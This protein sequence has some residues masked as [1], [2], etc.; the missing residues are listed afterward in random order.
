MQSEKLTDKSKRRCGER[1]GKGV[2]GE[3]K[4][5]MVSNGKAGDGKAIDKGN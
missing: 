5:S 3:T 2:Q 1:E 4:E